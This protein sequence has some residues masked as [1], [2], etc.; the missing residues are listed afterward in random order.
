VVPVALAGGRKDRA[1]TLMLR[2]LD[3]DPARYVPHRTHRDER[4][5]AET[6][7]Y[8]D[9]WTEV[10]HASGFDPMACLPFTLGVDLEGDQWT[11]SKFPIADLRRLYGIDVIELNIWRPLLDHVEEQLALGRPLIVETDGWYLPDTR[12]TSYRAEHV[13]TSIAIQMVDR[14]ARRLGYFHN[15]GYFELSGED[16][17]RTFH[18]DESTGG[19]HLPLYVEVA[20]LNAGPALSGSDLVAASRLLL[21]EQLERRPGSNPFVRYAERFP[22]DLDWL[23]GEPLSVFHQYAFSGLRQCGAALELAALY[24]RW[25]DG[26]GREGLADSAAAFESI[27]SSAKALQFKTARFVNTRKAFD[28]APILADM[29]EKW[30]AGMS[31]LLHSSAV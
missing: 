14:E 8:V 16:F 18:L 26:S 22:R 31:Q 23:T 19:F 4:I 28:P 10:L 11:F 15:A 29:A 13:K 6:N 2:L 27:S 5:W 20:K 30:E 7:C 12:G 9:L 3:L 25:L 17:D 24:L 21:Q 1:G